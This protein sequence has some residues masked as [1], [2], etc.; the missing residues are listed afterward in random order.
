MKG[1]TY[2]KLSGA[3]L[4]L[5]L[6][7]GSCTNF[8]TTSWGEIFR[9]NPKNV[10]VTTS[11]VY[12]LLKTARGDREL[13]MA[14]L[15]QISDQIGGLNK[16]EAKTLK[17]AAIK[18]A[19]QAADVTSKALENVGRII[20]AIDLNNGV[21]DI[22]AVAEEI[23][24]DMQSDDLRHI[25]DKITEILKDDIKLPPVN[26]PKAALIN[27]ETI[28]VPVPPKGGS[29]APPA[30]ITLD[31]KEN[32]TGTVTITVGDNEPVEY[33]CVINDDGTITL[34]GAGEGGEDAVLHYDINEDDHTLTLSDLDEIAIIS[35]GG[36]ED[37]SDPSKEVVVGEGSKITLDEDM[38]D[39]PGSDLGLMAM[40]LVL[41]KAQKEEEKY[42]DLQGYL[43]TWKDK[44]LDTGKGLDTDE[45]IIVAV[46][47][48]MIENGDDTSLLE[49]T[50]KNLLGVE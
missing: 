19:N 46:V 41:A 50:I 40:T 9:R 32:G 20:D 14:I 12:D 2:L 36:Y 28:T 16:E 18:A 25:S 48:T 44:N 7:L 35:E 26:D 38:A 15:D 21:D 31:I 17:H 43:D 5:L 8:F 39:V 1:K 24:K 47:N 49:K 34:P 22:K 23:L 33:D 3:A 11:N 27:T 30:T 45:V 13:S 10:K 29:E 37:S 4:V 42:G 6:L